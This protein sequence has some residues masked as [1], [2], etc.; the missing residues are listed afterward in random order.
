MSVGHPVGGGRARRGARRRAAG[1]EHSLLILA[2]YH[3]GLKV[4]GERRA[5]CAAPHRSPSLWIPVQGQLHIQFT[6]DVAST[7]Y[8]LTV[9]SLF[10]GVAEELIAEGTQGQVRDDLDLRELLRCL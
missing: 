2:R 6:N 8:A 5:S 9:A 7:M 4:E 3:A 1:R 10:S